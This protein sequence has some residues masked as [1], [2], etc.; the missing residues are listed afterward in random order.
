MH[1]EAREYGNN[2]LGGADGSQAKTIQIV[3]IG[4]DLDE[5][6]AIKVVNGEVISSESNI[7][8]INGMK[9]YS[10]ENAPAGIYI[11]NGKKIFKNK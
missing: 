5:A 1:A 9:I 10:L 7:Y 6:T 8:T 11:V 4:E 3:A 2:N